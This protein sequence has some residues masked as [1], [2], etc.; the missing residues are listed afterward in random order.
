[1]PNINFIWKQVK[2]KS[3]LQSLE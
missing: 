3:I 1:M 2:Q